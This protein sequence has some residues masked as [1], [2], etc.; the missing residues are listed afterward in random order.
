MVMIV[1]PVEEKYIPQTAADDAGQ[2]A[3]HG[4]I[5]DMD[6]PAAAVPF[7]DI[8]RRHAGCDDTGQKKQA[9]GTDRK[10]TDKK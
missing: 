2:T 1:R 8:I 7:H 3:V 10:G 5:K 4:E 9:V 6:M